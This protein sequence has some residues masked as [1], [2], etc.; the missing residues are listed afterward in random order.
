MSIFLSVSLASTRSL[1]YN[2]ITSSSASK[3]SV[4]GFRRFQTVR[5]NR[6]I[7]TT[8]TSINMSSA[9]ATVSVVDIA[10]NLEDVRHWIHQA[11]LNTSSNTSSSSSPPLS[12]KT[13]QLVAVS[14][15]KPYELLMA[16][17]DQGQRIFG[18]NYAQELIDKAQRMPSDVHWHYIGTL[19]S[20]KVNGLVKAVIPKAASLTVETVSSLKIAK[21]LNTAMEGLEKN[22]N[23]NLHPGKSSSSS[24]SRLAIFVQVN[25]SG[26][27]SKSGVDPTDVVSLCKEIKSS[28]ENLQLK[29]LM[30]IGAE[31][32][33]SCF[34]C[35][36][37]CRKEVSE[38]LDIPL[39]ELELSM[40]MSGDF[41]EAIA[42]GA[43]YVRIGSTIFG[44][45]DYSQA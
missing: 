20:N 17:Y 40:G 37:Q 38:A 28:C 10:R 39:D 27:D 11:S 43:T 33:L 45:R 26:E 6:F 34:D 19:Q 3:I 2:I 8:T 42:K 44:A 12:Q 1:A 21:K 30:T 25:T 4:V 9:D 16:A 36:V 41:K 7:T 23:V 14:K 35:L 15:T 31:G 5:R 32:D 18:E 24:S 13:V 29:G 22:E